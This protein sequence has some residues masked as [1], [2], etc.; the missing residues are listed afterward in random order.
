MAKKKKAKKKAKGKP[1]GGRPPLYSTPEKLEEKIEE[2]FKWCLSSGIKST[3]PG[4]ALHLGFQS[5]KAL[6]DLLIRMEKKRAGLSPRQRR[7]GANIIAAEFIRVINRA[8]L[9]IESQRM[10]DLVSGQKGLRTR[11]MEFDLMCNFGY[12]PKEARDHH[13][14]EPD[15]PYRKE[16]K[17]K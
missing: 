3:I 2:Y 12:V 13:F 17:T 11:G 15:F 8:R 7:A 14:P 5:R 1:A 4:L 16:D 6:A 9:T 10:A